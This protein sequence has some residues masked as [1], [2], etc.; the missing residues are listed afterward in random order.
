MRK[1]MTKKELKQQNKEL[2]FRIENLKSVNDSFIN[3]ELKRFS[4][5]NSEHDLEFAQEIY[6]WLKEENE[7]IDE[8]EQKELWNE[9]FME[10]RPRFVSVDNNEFELNFENDVKNKFKLVKL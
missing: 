4:I 1:L 3:L 6:R 8:T 10:M 5:E 9:F 7:V 2:L